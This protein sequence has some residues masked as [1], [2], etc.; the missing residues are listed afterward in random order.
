M[1]VLAEDSGDTEEND[2]EQDEEA[3]VMAATKAASEAHASSFRCLVQ[4][5]LASSVTPDLARRLLMGRRDAWQASSADVALVLEAFEV[6][7]CTTVVQ[8]TSLAAPSWSMA[9][10]TSRASQV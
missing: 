7:P 2:E 1:L 10:M 6:R 5:K 9:A 3:A 8:R 4:S